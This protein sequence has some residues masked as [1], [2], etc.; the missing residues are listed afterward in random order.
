MHSS[1]AILYY[2]QPFILGGSSGLLSVMRDVPAG[3]VID[4]PYLGC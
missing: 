1:V 4:L 2:L 3:A